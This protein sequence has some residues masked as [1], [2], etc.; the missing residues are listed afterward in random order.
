MGIFGGGGTE[1]C[2]VGR[3]WSFWYGELEWGFFIVVVVLSA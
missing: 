3:A 2:G 1:L